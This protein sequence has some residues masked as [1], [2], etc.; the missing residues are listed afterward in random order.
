MPLLCMALYSSL[1]GIFNKDH[2]TFNHRF[3]GSM[4]F[5]NLSG[6]DCS[7]VDLG[8]SVPNLF[9]LFT[10]DLQIMLAE[11]PLLTF[12]VHHMQFNI[13]LFLKSIDSRFW[14]ASLSPETNIYYVLLI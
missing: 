6:S 12:Y 3:V 1:F 13:Y 2:F 14:Y 8:F 4:P 5:Q 9:I 10:H 11:I 7:F